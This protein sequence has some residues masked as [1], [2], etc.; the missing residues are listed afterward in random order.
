M[1]EHVHSNAYTFL[2]GVYVCVCVAAE[3][4]ALG[5]PGRGS[6]VAFQLFAGLKGYVCQNVGQLGDIHEQ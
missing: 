4:R 1:N 2:C 3:I 6:L 5:Y